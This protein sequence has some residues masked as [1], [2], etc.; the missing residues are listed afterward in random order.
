M[1]SKGWHESPWL[2]IGGVGSEAAHGPPACAARQH[3]RG[4]ALSRRTTACRKLEGSWKDAESHLRALAHQ[5]IYCSEGSKTAVVFPCFPLRSDYK[6]KCVCCQ[7]PMAC[8]SH[9]AGAVCPAGG[10]GAPR[11]C[12]WRP[13]AMAAVLSATP[14]ATQHSD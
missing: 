14:P 7:P 9:P 4:A 8:Y 3:G 11:G 10:Q 5:L 2:W 13:P 6:H 1:G 12:S